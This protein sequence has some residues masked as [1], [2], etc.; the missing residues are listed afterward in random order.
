MIVMELIF[1]QIKPP[2]KENLFSGGYYMKNH[3]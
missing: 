3:R 2:K 1:L